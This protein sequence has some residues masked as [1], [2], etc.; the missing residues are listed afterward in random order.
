MKSS[1]ASK[2]NGPED[3]NE[4]RNDFGVRGGLDH[5]RLGLPPYVSGYRLSELERLPACIARIEIM[6]KFD[7]VFV[8]FPTEKYFL[9]ADKSW[10]ID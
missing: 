9:A 7:V 4:D 10:K 5:R 3:E 2:A 6:P 8:L 1:F